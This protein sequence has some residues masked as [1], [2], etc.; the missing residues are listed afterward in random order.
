VRPA[1]VDSAQG[2]FLQRQ[3]WILGQLARGAYQQLGA[4]IEPGQRRKTIQALDVDEF[5]LLEAEAAIGNEEQPL[6]HY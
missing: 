4:V 6:I 1:R 2:E 3:Q 5:Q